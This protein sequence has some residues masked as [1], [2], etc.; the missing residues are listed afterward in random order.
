PRS[1]LEIGFNLGYSAAC[2]LGYGVP[3]LLSIDI[4]PDPIL[5]KAALVLADR[6][7]ERFQFM[8]SDSTHSDT[9]PVL[10]FRAFYCVFIDGNHELDSLLSDIRL[11]KALGIK[12][13]LFDDWYPETG[14]GVQPAVLASDLKVVDVLGG[15]GY[16]VTLGP[17]WHQ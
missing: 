2:W 5:Q 14:P 10:E 3:H 1:M 8:L 4:H 6:Y 13:L 12:H 17:E 11:A 9:L 16:C 15:F 7:R